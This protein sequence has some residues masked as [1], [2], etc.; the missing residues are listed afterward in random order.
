MRA[1]QFKIYLTYFN[2][3]PFSNK[4]HKLGLGTPATQSVMENTASGKIIIDRDLSET[5]PIKVSISPCP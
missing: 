2:I 1:R 3:K 5:D 4:D